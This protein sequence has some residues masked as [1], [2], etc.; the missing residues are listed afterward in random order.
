MVDLP[1][2]HGWNDR[3][4]GREGHV[5]Q[6]HIGHTGPWFLRYPSAA[7]KLGDSCTMCIYCSLLKVE[8]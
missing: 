5:N 3:D 1:Q 6:R 8:N 2:T 4:V 7:W